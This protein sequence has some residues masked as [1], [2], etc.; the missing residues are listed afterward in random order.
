MGQIV[1][2]RSCTFSK[3]LIPV[4]EGGLAQVI[5]DRGEGFDV[6]VGVLVIGAGAAGLVTAL[7]A[8]DEG[9]E[10]LVAERD[11]VPGG[12]TALSAGL[13]PA[14]GTRFQR[15]AG[16][17]DRAAEFAADIIR[18]AHG[19][20]DRRAV[21]RLVSAIAPAVEWLADRHGLPFSIVGD[22]TYPGHSARRMHGLPNRSGAELMDYL[23]SAAE[24]SGAGI[25]TR[26]TVHT[27]V[28]KG[29]RITGAIVRRADGRDERI[30]ASAIVLACNG[31][32][33][34]A[35]IVRRE[36][37]EIAGAVYFGHA[38]NQGDAVIWGEALGAK[39]R[40]L[41]AYQGHGSVAYPHGILIT[42]A[43]IT[44]G[45][46]QIN[47]EGQRFSDESRGYSEAAASVIAQP[48][49][50]AFNVFDERVAAVASQFEDFGIARQQGAVFTASTAGELAG[51][52]KVPRDALTGTFEAVA[53]L[54]RT[55]GTDG[56]NRVWRGV[57][58]LEPP[59]CAVRVTGALFHTQGGLAVDQNARVIARDGSVF[60]NLF[61]AGGAACGVSGAQASGYLSGNGLLAAIGYGYIAGHAAGRIAAPS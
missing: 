55:G 26:G 12:S 6:Q 15:A 21:E 48:G 49:S 17:A 20:P 47:A 10:V 56:W 23:R 59:Y 57:A 16:I 50:I 60:E 54:K 44:E 45:G 38:G 13:I 4:K 34:N 42:W 24:G 29:Q 58:Q 2:S 32:G 37:P 9:A 28:R 22:F 52:I 31:Y 19:E 61:A 46:F 41:S 1:A 7:R 14:A 25:L 11:S 3:V 8:L 27:L 35:E 30:G 39:I 40:H 53:G 43:T 36:I 5:E 51:K 18:K 33:G